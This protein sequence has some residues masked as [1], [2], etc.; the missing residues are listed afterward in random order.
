M[1]RK[2]SSLSRTAPSGAGALDLGPCAA[3]DFLQQVD[4]GV[5]PVS[6][7]SVVDIEEGLQ[8]PAT[9]D[10][11][12]HQG[13][14][15]QP[16]KDL[17]RIAGATVGAY[18]GDLDNTS[19]GQIPDQLGAE[20]GE[21]ELSLGADHARGPVTAHGDQ[22]AL[23]IDLAVA[24]TIRTQLGAERAF[25]LDHDVVRRGQIAQ[26]V[27]EG[28]QEGLPPL[29]RLE[30]VDGHAG[31]GDVERHAD[32]AEEGA[33]RIETGIH[34]HPHPAPAVVEAFEAGLE[35]VGAVFRPGDL[36]DPLDLGHIVGMQGP[37][38]D[39]AQNFIGRMAVKLDQRSVDELHLGV[40]VGHP[41]RE[42]AVSAIRRKRLS[43]SRRAASAA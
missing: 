21:A 34:G 30:R 33:V 40:G 36:H 39:R 25:D 41:D 13:A 6:D 9:D 31:V 7:F 43:L 27:G 4:L 3:G 23:L 22:I 16:F 15:P 24:D 1:A 28:Q 17:Q 19:F 12:A 10:G 14:G 18:V 38:P 2:R 29:L 32:V 8:T 20:V 5:G 35:A 11:R 42:G 37:A 26:A